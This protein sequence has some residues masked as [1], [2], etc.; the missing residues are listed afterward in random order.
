MLKSLRKLEKIYQRPVSLLS[1]RFSSNLE[2]NSDDGIKSQTK[3]NFLPKNGPG[4]KEFLARDHLAE[5]NN[6]GSDEALSN[7]IFMKNLDNLKRYTTDG[8]SIVEKRKVFFEVHGCQMNVNDTEVAYAI[9]DKTGRYERTVEEQEADVVL[10]MTCSIREN[11]EQKIWNRLREFCF[12]KRHNPGMQ[13]GVLGCMA[14]RLKDK[15]VNKERLVDVVC[16]PDS[17][18]LLPTLLEQSL[19]SGNAAVNVQL[20]LEETYAEISPLRIY[21]AS[22][23]A[24]IS[25][26]RGC[27]NM[28]SFVWTSNFLILIFDLFLNIL[29]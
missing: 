7:D 14:E 23:M 21:P 27:D 2:L 16:G 25:I 29:I 28:C 22:K 15:I 26:Q 19:E 3:K 24:Y 10:I 17:Y 9:L 1:N 6:S 12:Q 8:T 5:I 20:S 18:R 11:S 4:L 13:I